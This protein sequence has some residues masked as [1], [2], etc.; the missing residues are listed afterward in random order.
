[1]FHPCGGRSLGNFSQL[2][3]IIVQQRPACQSAV[4]PKGQLFSATGDPLVQ[5][6][7]QSTLKLEAKS[8]RLA[9]QVVFFFDAWYAG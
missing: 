8:F 9:R 7:Q 3:T 2:E 1:M 6:Q 5:A 4:L